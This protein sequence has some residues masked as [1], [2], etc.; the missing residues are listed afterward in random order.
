MRK[1]IAW[2][3]V[4]GL[5]WFS[6]APV[7]PAQ[8]TSAVEG[9]V[10]NAA[11]RPLRDLTVEIFAAEGGQPVGSALQAGVTDAQGNWA[12]S[13][14]TPGEYVVQA[15]NGVSSFGVPVTVGATPTLG[16]QM[17]APSAFVA[18]AQGAAAAAGMSALQWGLVAVGAGGAATAAAV[19]VFRDDES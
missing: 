1:M 7:M 12:F 6:P 19:V 10:V 2:L 5:L 8:A 15:A 4:A 16:V 3:A 17:L 13:G 9:R 18:G 11:G 14:L